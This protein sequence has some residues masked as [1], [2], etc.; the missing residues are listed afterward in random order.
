VAF[1]ITAYAVI[2]AAILGYVLRLWL[3]ER[4]CRKRMEML[5]GSD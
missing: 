2:I 4:A 3:A 1:L 5:R